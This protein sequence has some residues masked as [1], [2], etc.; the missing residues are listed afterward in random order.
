MLCGTSAFWAL[1]DG[2]GMRENNPLGV[3]WLGI[4]GAEAV[5]DDEK[6]LFVVEGCEKA[7]L[8]PNETGGFAIALLLMLLSSVFVLSWK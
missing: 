4:A 8:E 7:E 3:A 1:C 6:M 5:F 2:S